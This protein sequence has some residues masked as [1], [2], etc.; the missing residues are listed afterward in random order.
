MLMSTN[1]LKLWFSHITQFRRL[2]GV[3]ILKQRPGDPKFSVSFYC[4]GSYSY[5]IL[6]WEINIQYKR[7]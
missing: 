2:T 5:H 1:N 3:K 6:K 7:T 4:Y